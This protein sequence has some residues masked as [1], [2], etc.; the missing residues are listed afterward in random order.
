M[1]WGD[2]AGAPRRARPV[3]RPHK[4]ASRTLASLRDLAPK[5]ISG[6]LWV[7]DAECFIR[8]TL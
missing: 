8:R 7:K 5:L 6:D 4:H 1:K 3:L 2:I